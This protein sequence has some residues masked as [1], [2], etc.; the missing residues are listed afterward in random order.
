LK[1]ETVTE[2]VQEKAALYALGAF[3]LMEARSF[4]LH[5]EEGCTICR[6]EVAR[7]EEVTSQLGLSAEMETPPAYLRDVLAARIQKEAQASGV[8]TPLHGAETRPPLHPTAR[9]EAATEPARR[10]SRWPL[11]LPWAIAAS[12]LIAGLVGFGLWQAERRNMRNL[13]AR[14]EAR[15]DQAADERAQLQGQ[16]SLEMEKATQLAQINDVLNS[17]G[18]RVIA[19]AGQPAAPQSSA[20]IYWDTQ[21]S[22]WVVTTDLPPAP[23]GK[24]YQLWF[25]TPSKEKISAGLI[26]HSATGQGFA[27][28][29]VPRDLGELS[30]AAITLEPEGGSPQPTSAIYVAGVTG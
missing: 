15:L 22:R 19:L 20:R 5:L 16:L 7:F 21:K 4:E 25:I 8:V 29:E 14:Q 18:V 3:S 12:L 11:I 10:P 1:H 13:I 2:E 23:E 6:Q 9:Q 30:Q 26:R 27:V 24:I 28:I 17:P